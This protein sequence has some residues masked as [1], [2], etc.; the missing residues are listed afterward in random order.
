MENPDPL[1]WKV[2]AVK[3]YEQLLKKTKKTQS[4]YLYLLTMELV[5]MMF[6]DKTKK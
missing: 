4:D 5:N 3:R 1:R 6:H 2:E